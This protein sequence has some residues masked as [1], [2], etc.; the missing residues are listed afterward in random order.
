MAEVEDRV[1]Y[2]SPV[3]GSREALLESDPSVA[4]NELIFPTDE[5]LARAR[6]FRGFTAE[7]DKVLTPVFEKL[8]T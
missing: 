4:K 2:I 5:V 8:I 6:S 1:N 3:T 7:E